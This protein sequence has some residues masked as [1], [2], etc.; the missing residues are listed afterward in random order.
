MSAID[1]LIPADVL[2]TSRQSA[3]HRCVLAAYSAAQAGASEAEVLAVSR[4][5]MQLAR[6]PTNQRGDS[7]VRGDADVIPLRPQGGVR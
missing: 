6:V 2:L 3:L 1:V 5:A 7:D 4:E